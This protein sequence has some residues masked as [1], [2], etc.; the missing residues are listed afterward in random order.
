MDPIYAPSITL[1]LFTGAARFLIREIK[2]MRTY[3]RIN[4]DTANDLTPC[5]LHC[6]PLT[7]LRFQVADPSE[8]QYEFEHIHDNR[9]PGR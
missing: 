2:H 1:S 7:R 9:R 5:A 4:V 8:L 6:C 3:F